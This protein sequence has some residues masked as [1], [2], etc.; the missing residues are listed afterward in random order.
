MKNFTQLIENYNDIR[1]K[2]LKDIVSLKEE[3][4]EEEF[5]KEVD[6]T[7]QQSQGKIRKKIANASVQAVE[8]QKEEVEQLD[9][10]L[11]KARQLYAQTYMKHG[12]TVGQSKDAQ[13]KAYDAVEKKHG[14]D[15]LAQLKSHHQ[16]NEEVELD[17][18]HLSSDEKQE[19][20]KNV[21]GMKKK[22]SDFRQR[23]GDKAKS[24]MYATATK[25]AKD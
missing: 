22:M 4:S 18:R 8:V 17:E 14:K 3:A 13:Q 23:Y 6:T 5:N 20:E 1:L 12:K 19:M 16:Q 11:M 9:E 10:N 24:V 15:V 7:K 2:A 21:K 25:M